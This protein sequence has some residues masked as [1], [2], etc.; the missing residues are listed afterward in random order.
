MSVHVDK[1][2]TDHS[3]NK[4]V[5]CGRYGLDLYSNIEQNTTI[6]IY[7]T[8][9]LIIEEACHGELLVSKEKRFIYSTRSVQRNLVLI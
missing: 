5:T 3:V 7:T 9:A 1:L 6:N 2:V 8:F 4:K